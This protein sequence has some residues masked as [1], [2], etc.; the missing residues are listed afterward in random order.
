MP[1]NFRPGRA[2]QALRLIPLDALHQ[3]LRHVGERLH[4]VQRGWLVK[5]AL[6]H[7]KRRFVARLGALALDGFNQ[8]ALF[9]ANISAGADE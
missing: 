5:H 3:N 6:R 4:I 8:R 1:T 7:R 2:A 9:A